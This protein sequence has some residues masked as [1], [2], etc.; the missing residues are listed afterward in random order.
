MF[1]IRLTTLL[2]PSI[3]QCELPTTRPP[4]T[5]GRSSQISSPKSGH[6][7]SGHLHEPSNE[8]ISKSRPYAME[9]A[10]PQFMLVLQF[11]PSQ[12]NAFY[13]TSAF[14]LNS[15]NSNSDNVDRQ[16]IASDSRSRVFPRMTVAQL[17]HPQN[18][19]SRPRQ[20]QSTLC[21]SPSMEIV[22]LCWFREAPK[23]PDPRI[24]Q[25]PGLPKATRCHTPIAPTTPKHARICSTATRAP[26]LH[27]SRR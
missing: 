15:N 11:A 19:P 14:Y 24:Y 2:F 26:Q 9:A 3:G 5:P 18:S 22:I 6:F 20:N 25:I 4:P 17:K 16:S 1:Q 13:W 27:P 23:M 8:E 12:Y 21:S 7:L 10:E